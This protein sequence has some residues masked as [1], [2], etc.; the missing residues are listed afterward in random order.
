[1][2]TEAVKQELVQ[3]VLARVREVWPN[4]AAGE[5]MHG[6]NDVLDGARLIDL[7]R[8]CRTDEV[9]AVLEVARA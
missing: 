7:V 6:S 9:L 5:W 2:D 3:A 1:M 8:L 4:E